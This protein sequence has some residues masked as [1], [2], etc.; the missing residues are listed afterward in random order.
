VRAQGAPRA[1]DGEGCL[2]GTHALSPLFITLL[3]LSDSQVERHQGEVIH[4]QL[5]RSIYYFHWPS[6][7]SMRCKRLC[8]ILAVP[9]LEGLQGV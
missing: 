2:C 3:S 5:V 9:G 7:T 8:E 1:G 4:R 6:K